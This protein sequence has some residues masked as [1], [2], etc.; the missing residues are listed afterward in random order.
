MPLS[1]FNLPSRH[2]C[3]LF[4]CLTLSCCHSY[5][6]VSFDFFFQAIL[7][8][9]SFTGHYAM[10]MSIMAFLYLCCLTIACLL[11]YTLSS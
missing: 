7:E 9:L 10:H 1:H 5:Q 8:H 11:Q 6:I 3:C 2:T 4:S